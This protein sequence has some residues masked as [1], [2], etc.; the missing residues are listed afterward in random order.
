LGRWK[1]NPA[2]KNRRYRMTDYSEDLNSDRGRLIALRSQ[3]LKKQEAQIK[4]ASDTFER[5]CAE[6]DVQFDHEFDVVRDEYARIRARP[7]PKHELPQH[8]L[9]TA[10]KAISEETEETIRALYLEKHI[11]G[12]P[13]YPLPGEPQ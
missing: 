2:T 1:D 10:T 9:D 6:E 8:K 13:R 4:E 7:R 5:E 12:D 11:T 3:T